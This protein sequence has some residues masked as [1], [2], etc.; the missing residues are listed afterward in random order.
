MDSKFKIKK[1]M[2]ILILIVFFICMSYLVTGVAENDF[3]TFK[4]FSK[5]YVEDEILVKFKDTTPD[6]SIMSTVQLLSSNVKREIVKEKLLLLKLKEGKSV[7]DAIADFKEIPD[8]KYV[9][10]NFIYKIM[11]TTPN[12]TYYP[13]LWGLK[14]TGQTISNPSYNNNN[15][16]TLGM[17]MDMELAWDFVTDCSSIIVAVIDSGV[18]YNHVDLA[19]N[20][21]N[22]AVNH[23][24]DFVGG[25]DN[26]MDLNGHGTHVAGTIGAVGNNSIGTTG[27][28]WDVSIMAVRVFNA[29]GTGTTADIIAGAYYAV[30]NGAKIL[31]MSLGG[32]NFDQALYDAIG[33]AKN[34]N[35]IVVAAA[36][37]NSTD[38]DTVLHVYPSDFDH[39]NIIS[40]TAL[41]QSYELADFS[42]YGNISVDVGAPGAN[43]TSEWCGSETTINDSFI[44]G[45]SASNGYALQFDGTNDVVPTSFMGA[46][47]ITTVAVWV[48][49]TGR[50]G[51]EQDI[52]C[53]FHS[54]GYGLLY[55]IGNDNKFTWDVHINGAYR[56]FASDSEIQLNRWYYIVGTYD[57]NNGYLYIDG[58]RQSGSIT[59]D[60]VITDSPYSMT[61]GA[62][63]QPSGFI[64][65]MKGVIDEVSIWS[66]ALT[67]AE[68]Q[69]NMN[70]HLN[71]D[72]VGLICYWKFDEGSGQRVEDS[73][74][75]NYDGYLGTDPNNPDMGDPTWIISDI[76]GSNGWTAGGTNGW[77]F[78]VRDLGFGDI[79]LLVDPSNWGPPDW[80]LYNNNADDRIWKT[81]NING[82]NSAVLNYLVMFDVEQGYDAFFTFCDNGTGDPF[83]NGYQLA[84]WTGSTGGYFVYE[85]YELLS[86]YITSTCTIGFNLST[87]NTIQDYG[88][89]I[90]DFSITAM[91]TN[92]TTY[93][94]INGTSMATPHV[95]G[96]A[97]LIWTFNPS[98]SYKEVFES[99]RNGGELVTSLNNKT[100]TGR[101]VNAWGSLRYIK[102]PTGI[103]IT[104]N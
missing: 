7:E 15:P 56:Y 103:V 93:N 75:N 20:M 35:V 27:I 92:N 98:Y 38:N 59:T 21:W 16:G 97:A 53:N 79:N 6:F 83:V 63:P 43:I 82:Y 54:S 87:D 91:T 1:L 12:D 32:S 34:N 45:P 84:G 60:G 10:P 74:A 40:V 9:Q 104:K 2:K 65:Y 90:L 50:T 41:D 58:V 48:K 94:I 18:N 67:D 46:N 55:D 28:C 78:A 81:F 49:I 44:S 13:N 101:A 100:T 37:N 3:K 31:N 99:V 85:K 14:N 62:N 30:D 42:N 26:P 69:T 5:R 102:A 23:G 70:Q 57:G 47:D 80:G 88:V 77:N 52:V 19:G 39:D 24:Y 72:E 68:I 36:G 89:A 61:I 4:E 22:G 33:Y 73:S 29:A 76:S 71:G 86:S 8:V 25:D 96:L 17:D 66:V 95:S 51:G 11:S 64:Q